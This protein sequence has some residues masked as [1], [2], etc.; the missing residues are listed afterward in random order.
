MIDNSNTAVPNRCLAPGNM[1]VI[2]QFQRHILDLAVWS[3]AFII[4]LKFNL[5][6]I[7][8]IYQRLLNEPN[9]THEIMST[10]F[11]EDNANKYENLL[12]RLIN[13]FVLLAEAMHINNVQQA[14]E[15]YQCL[16]KFTDDI[17]TFFY[18]LNPLTN[19]DDWRELFRE[20]VD[21][22]Y[23]EIYTIISGN[24]IGDIE[25]FDSIMELSYRIANHISQT[26]ISSIQTP[27][28]K[29]ATSV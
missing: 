15:N 29:P 24:F 17:S 25:L 8:D 19:L 5:P 10:F 28:I 22:L 1:Y 3:R 9:D 7:G 20:Y 21:M 26:A 6:N 4:A 27:A 2:E 16:I 13:C 11:G 12:I 14:N 23:R 18:E